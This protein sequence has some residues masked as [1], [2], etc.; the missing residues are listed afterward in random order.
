MARR[1]P[2]GPPGR[3]PVGTYRKRLGA[4]PRAVLGLRGRPD[5][6]FRQVSASES[7]ILNKIPIHVKTQTFGLGPAENRRPHSAIKSASALL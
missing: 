2:Y 7:L 5:E 3:V 6:P 1:E 4:S